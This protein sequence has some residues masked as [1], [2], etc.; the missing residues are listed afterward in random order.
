MSAAFGRS[1]S[2]LSANRASGGGNEWRQTC[3]QNLA[4]PK[5]RLRFVTLPCGEREVPAPQEL[6]AAATASA[7]SPS[8]Q[9]DSSEDRTSAA[10]VAP[11]PFVLRHMVNHG[12]ATAIAKFI[13]DCRLGV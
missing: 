9:R 8:P 11:A 4:L 12:R 5:A 1:S 7:T 2:T 10:Y 13:A 6:L 3:H